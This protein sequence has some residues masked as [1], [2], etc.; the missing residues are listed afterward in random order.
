MFGIWVSSRFGRMRCSSSSASSSRCSSATGVGRSAAV[1]P[2][3]SS[4]SRCGPCIVRADRWPA[5]PRHH[6]L[7]RPTSATAVR[8]S[9]RR[10]GSGRAASASGVRWRSV[11]SVRGSGVGGG[12]FRCRRSVTRSR[13]ESFWRRRSAGSGNY[14]NQELY[15][16]ADDLAVGAGDLRAPRCQWRARLAERC[17]DGSAG[18]T[19]V[20][21]TF[22][23]ELLWNLSGF[24][25]ADLGGPPIPDR[26]RAAVRVVCRRHTASVGSG[27]S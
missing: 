23:Y 25:A 5:L 10:F 24:R 14:F 11:A 7:D 27:S 3:S 1:N 2:G 15:G 8:A 26:P 19:V 9:G 4:T 18:R 20:H 13:R 6:R 22:L 17:V 21:P 16:R 12:A